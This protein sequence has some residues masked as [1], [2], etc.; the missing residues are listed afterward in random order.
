MISLFAIIEG[1]DDPK[2]C[3]ARKLVRMKLVRPI[4]DPRKLPGEA[5][6]LNPLAEKAL[7]RADRKRAMVSGIVVLDCSWKRLEKFPKLRKDLRHRALPF[8]IAANPVNFGHPCALSSAEALAAALWVLGEKEQ[9]ELV[10]SKFG[11]GKSF[12]ALNRELLDA[13]ASA[14]DSAA[15]VETQKEYI[16]ESQEKR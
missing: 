15:V 13:Y 14:A 9:A 5:I 8:L 7:S 4:D 2:K 3:T 1:E 16:R 12:I 6:V 10:M 11:W